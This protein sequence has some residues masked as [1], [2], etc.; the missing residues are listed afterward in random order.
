[1]TSTNEKNINVV[2]EKISKISKDRLDKLILKISPTKVLFEAVQKCS[3][4]ESGKA[5]NF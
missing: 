4:T 1:M 2:L 5:S 3:L